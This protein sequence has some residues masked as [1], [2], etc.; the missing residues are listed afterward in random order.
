MN[1]YLL[2]FAMV[3][4]VY[5][6]CASVITIDNG[7]F[8]TL[9]ITDETFLAF[10]EF[11]DENVDEFYINNSSIVIDKLSDW[12]N[13]DADVNFSGVVSL[14]IDNIDEFN[15]GDEIRY[16]NNQ[17]VIINNANLLSDNLYK[18][19]VSYRTDSG[20]FY[21][22][23]VRETNYQKIFNDGRGEFLET[24][25]LNHPND[26]IFNK[27]DRAGN[28]QAVYRGMNSSYHFKPAIL[29]RPIKTINRSHLNLL[30]DDTDI[31]VGLNIGYLFSGKINDYSSNLYI[32]HKYKDLYLNMG[33][34]L[35]R[36]T[37]KDSTNEFNGFMYGIDF[38]AKQYIN[39]GFWLDGLYGINRTNFDAKYIYT[40]NK[41][42]NNPASL[43]QYGRLSVGYDYDKIS[44]V[45][46]A[47][48][49][50]IMFQKSE[51]YDD[52][53]TDINLHAGANAKYNI[54]M[55]GIKYEY[56]LVVSGDEKAFWHV[57]TNAGFTSVADNAG[58][59]INIDVFHDEF[60]TNCKLSLNA[61]I[62][63]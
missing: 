12:Q 56:G 33:L 54:V 16:V 32:G 7:N 31:G 58:V 42:K 46:I 62:S 2:S 57:G 50:G 34:N 14:Y 25:R 55:D 9:E 6:A 43:S 38:R 28:M 60:D 53:D 36:F 22:N 4:G 10:N 40:D 13:W 15:D 5:N 37:Y 3:F 19:D 48:F 51:V 20:K 30:S 21:L 18:A 35:D 1:K 59:S 47:P 11:K 45:I 41:V 17:R 26:K 39:G 63:F 24:L 29:M 52:S 27:I 44:D 23:L 61:N 8:S 49:I